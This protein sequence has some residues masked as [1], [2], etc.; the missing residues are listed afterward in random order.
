MKQAIRCLVSLSTPLECIEIKTRELDLI[1]SI[2][3]LFASKVTQILCYFLMWQKEKMR[4]LLELI[5][6]YAS[7]ISKSNSSAFGS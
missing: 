1:C 5:F 6:F 2:I 7:S 4:L 3:I